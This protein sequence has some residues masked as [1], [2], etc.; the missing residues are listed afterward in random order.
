MSIDLSRPL[1]PAMGQHD[2]LDGFVTYS[3]LQATAGKSPHLNLSPEIADMAGICQE[4]NWAT[5]DR[6]ASGV[7]SSTPEG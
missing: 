5:D 7:S 3:E 4:G 6:S 1:V 2:P